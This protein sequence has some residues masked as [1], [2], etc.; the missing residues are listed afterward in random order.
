MEQLNKTPIINNGREFVLLCLVEHLNSPNQ[1][2]V[3]ATNETAYIVPGTDVVVETRKGW[4][5]GVVRE[6]TVVRNFY[7]AGETQFIKRLA[8]ATI[9]FRRVIKKVYYTDIEYADAP[10]II[11]LTKERD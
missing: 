6:T 2:F 9:P 8:N 11:D 10:K 1:L 5:L 4:T 7:E 3:F